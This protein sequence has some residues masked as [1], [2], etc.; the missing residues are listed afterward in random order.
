M[1]PLPVALIFI[2]QLKTSVASKA[3]QELKTMAGRD[4]GGRTKSV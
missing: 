1:P 2:M 3:E 4:R